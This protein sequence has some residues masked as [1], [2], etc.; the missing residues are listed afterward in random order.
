MFL[1][2]SFG[3]LSCFY[4]DFIMSEKAQHTTAHLREKMLEKY[5]T[6]LKHKHNKI[7]HAYR[8]HCKSHPHPVNG[9]DGLIS[10][11]KHEMKIRKFRKHLAYEG[12]H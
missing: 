6:E 2:L 7:H 1:N 12:V 8:A 4:K 10:K 5:G 11:Y 9:E 3:L